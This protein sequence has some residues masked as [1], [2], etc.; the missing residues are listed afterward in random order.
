MTMSAPDFHNDPLDRLIGRAIRE[1][2][3]E[4][5]EAFATQTAAFV[6]TEARRSS[7]RVEFWLER[8]LIAALI[9]A[10]GVTLFVTAGPALNALASSASAGWIYTG[11]I[12]LGVSMVVQRWCLLRG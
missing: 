4:L 8:G 7:D 12:C 9:V 11:A 3:D 2:S 1:R 10:V 6:E 5:P